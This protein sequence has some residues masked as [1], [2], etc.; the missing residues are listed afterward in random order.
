MEVYI[1][2]PQD[3]IEKIA[4]ILNADPEAIIYANQ[5]SEPY[6]LVPGQALLIPGA[7]SQRRENRPFAHVMGYAYP[8]ISP[9]TLAESLPYLSALLVF[10]YGFT[11]EGDLVEPVLDDRWM[12]QACGEQGTRPFLTFTSIGPDGRFQS[13][14]VQ[15]LLQRPALQEKVIWELGRV[16]HE[17][18][19]MGLDM[20][21]EY[22]PA[23]ERVHYADF[24]E[25]ARKVMN[26]FGYPVSVALAPKTSG[27]Q[28]GLLYEG[29]D[30]GLL[31]QAAN[32]SFLMTYE[33]G[34]TYGPPMA[35]APLH[36]VRRVAEYALT[37]IPA[38]QLILGI[39]NYGYDWPLPYERGTTKAS[40]IGNREAVQ[41]AVSVGASIQYDEQAQSPYFHYQKD[42]VRHEVWFEDVRSYEA[43][44]RLVQELGLK[45]F[46]FWQMMK[47]FRAGLLLADDM[48]QIIKP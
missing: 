17:K 15:Q 35:V 6:D 27:E 3:S 47:L 28:K 14:L 1:V 13:S 20:D 36:M 34:Y 37:E 26:L 10:S 18:G 7:A 19:F 33:W 21:F 23:E 25:L 44:Y 39:P 42:G 11:E 32:Q 48:F 41:L 40:T 43:K 24:V 12:I 9:Q 30:Y 46:G 45:G 8:F 5:L 31:G 16:I 38:N 22:I 2:Q 29:I 4:R